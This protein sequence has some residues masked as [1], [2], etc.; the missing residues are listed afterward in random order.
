MKEDR[1]DKEPCAMFQ[2]GVNCDSVN[3]AGNEAPISKG[4]R[5]FYK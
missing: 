5:D 2:V 3:V 4:S 1:Q